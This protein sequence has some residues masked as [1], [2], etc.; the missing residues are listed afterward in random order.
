MAGQTLKPTCHSKEPASIR[1][2]PTPR[3]SQLQKFWKT[4]IRG[5]AR[6]NNNDKTRHSTTG[7]NTTETHVMTIQYNTIHHNMVQ[8]I[9]LKPVIPSPTQSFKMVRSPLPSTGISS[10]RALNIPSKTQGCRLRQLKFSR[11]TMPRNETETEI[12]KTLMSPGTVR[13]Q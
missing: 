6:I 4:K 13:K 12:S 10:G 8:H 7:Y 5:F 9:F 1:S 3:F 11:P 2:Y